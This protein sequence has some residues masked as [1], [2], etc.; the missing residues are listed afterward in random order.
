[1][2]LAI[3][4][5]TELVGAAVAEGTEVRAEA[6]VAG[7]RRHAE[8]LAPLVDQV[9]AAA[10]VEVAGL[11]VV[12][13]DVGPGLFT[14]LR[15]GVAMA[16]GLAFAAGINVVPVS[17]LTTLARAAFDTGFTGDVLAVVDARRAEVFAARFGPAPGGHGVPVARDVPRRYEPGE[18]GAVLEEMVPANG[19][20][21]LAVGDGALRYASHFEGVHGVTVAGPSLSAPPPGAL[22]V[23][24]AE[25]LAEGHPPHDP[26]AVEAVYLREA[27]ARINWVTRTTAPSVAGES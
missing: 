2:L 23:L 18:L 8:T 26:I 21:L 13:V 7:R 16:K 10:E 11:S 24:A 27:D 12:A 3:E 17:S 20:G 25:W 19:D 1:M 6:W 9:L 4:T 22:A 5:A 14:G 15:V